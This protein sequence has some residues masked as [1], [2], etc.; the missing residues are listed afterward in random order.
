MRPSGS[1]AS[2]SRRPAKRHSVCSSSC[3]TPVARSSRRPAELGLKVSTATYYSKLVI[4]ER[5]PSI[6]RAIIAT[7]VLSGLRASELC[8]LEWRHI[9]LLNRQITVPGT[10]SDAADRVVKIV[11]F[12]LDELQRWKLDA[13]STDPDDLV[14][15]TASGRQRT[16]DNLRSNV[17][18][19]AVREANRARALDDLAPLPQRTSPH[20]LRRTFVKLMLAYGNPTKSVQVEAGHADRPD[21]A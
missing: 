7:L 1:T 9:D 18:P 17:V 11:D 20:V 15:P 2:T 13:P 6:R 10:K 21:D 19:P 8:A 16:K 3:D 5:E 4:A 12:L 14:F